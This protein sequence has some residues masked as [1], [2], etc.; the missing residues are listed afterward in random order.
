[1]ITASSGLQLLVAW[2]LSMAISFDPGAGDQPAV[3][4]F[5]LYLSPPSLKM[6]EWWMIRSMT[7]T[8]TWSFAKNSPEFYP[9]AADKSG[10][11]HHKKQEVSDETEETTVHSSL[12]EHSIRQFACT[13]QR[14]APRG[15]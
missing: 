13:L 8:A 14:V 10:N 12:L 5:S 3:F 15:D 9:I 6:C 11:L 2:M 4:F 1:M 7:G